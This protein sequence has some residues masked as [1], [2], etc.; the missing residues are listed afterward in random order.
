MAHQYTTCFLERTRSYILEVFQETHRP[1]GSA[2]IGIYHWVVIMFFRLLRIGVSNESLWPPAR[3]CL[4]C[5][6]PSLTFPLMKGILK[7]HLPFTEQSSRTWN[8][9]P[10]IMPYGMI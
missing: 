10:P 5:P 2:P 9:W 1:R 6:S 7:L 4:A 3:K 8:L